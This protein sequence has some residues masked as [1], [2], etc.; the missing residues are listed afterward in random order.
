MDQSDIERIKK[1]IDE[2]HE[3]PSVFMFKFIVPSDNVRIAEVE[4]LFNTQTAQIRMNAS[5]NGKYTSITA[6]E[7]VTDAENVMDVYKK[8]SKIEGLIAL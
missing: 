2:T 3:W 7:V 1:T 5:R 4:A 6:H 8:A